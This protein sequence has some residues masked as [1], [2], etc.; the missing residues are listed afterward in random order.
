[1]ELLCFQYSNE[2][3]WDTEAENGERIRYLGEIRY[4]G[5][6]SKHTERILPSFIFASRPAAE[7][8]LNMDFMKRRF[9]R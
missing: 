9:E 1:M 7:F 2:I 3:P 8:L 4:L 6:R 5:K